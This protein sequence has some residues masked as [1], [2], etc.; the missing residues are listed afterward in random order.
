MIKATPFKR[1]AG[2]WGP[3]FS[4]GYS[5]GEFALTEKLLYG[6]PGEFALTESFAPGISF[7]GTPIM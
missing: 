6:K 3:V 7:D 2:P 1:N 4:C 5:L